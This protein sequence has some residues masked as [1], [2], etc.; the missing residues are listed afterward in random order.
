MLCSS[1]RRSYSLCKPSACA[2]IADKLF[3]LFSY[4]NEKQ[5]ENR[6][7][8]YAITINKCYMTLSCL[9][10]HFSE[11]Q[12]YTRLCI[13][14]AVH[15][16]PLFLYS[17]FTY[18]GKTTCPFFRVYMIIYSLKFSEHPSITKKGHRLWR[19]RWNVKFHTRLCKIQNLLPVA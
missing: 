16:M 10:K 17:M 1:K 5:K 4:P 18:V 7:T 9:L 13:K 2:F 15:Y 14:S 6:S 19:E 11:C 3:S 8:Y 12:S